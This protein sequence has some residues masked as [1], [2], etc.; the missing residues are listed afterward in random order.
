MTGNLKSIIALISIIVLCAFSTFHC[1]SEESGE[2]IENRILEQLDKDI[3][4]YR[5]SDAIIEVLNKDGKPVSNAGI[6]IRQLNSDFLFAA[7]VTLITGDLGG[8]I[9]IAHY[10]YQPRLKTQAEDDRFKELFAELFNC[11]TIKL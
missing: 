4:K 8:T 5:K 7:N 1:L 9:P 3:E 6:K 2:A 10:N 11:A